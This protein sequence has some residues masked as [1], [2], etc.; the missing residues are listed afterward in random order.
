MEVVEGVE[1][2]VEGVKRSLRRIG[3]DR[4]GRWLGG[5]LF[6]H[7]KSHVGLLEGVV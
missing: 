2:V 6:G 5:F 7:V 3:V 1:E 4:G